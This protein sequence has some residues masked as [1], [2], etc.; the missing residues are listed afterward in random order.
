MQ[1]HHLESKISLA[2]L[3]LFLGSPQCPPWKKNQ[4]PQFQLGTLLVREEEKS[5][6]W[7]F[8]WLCVHSEERCFLIVC[9]SFK[10]LKK[11]K[12]S[13]LCLN[14]LKSTHSQASGNCTAKELDNCV[15]ITLKESKKTVKSSGLKERNELPSC[16]CQSQMETM[17]H[18]G[19]TLVY[20]DMDLS[21]SLIYWEQ[22]T[23]WTPLMQSQS[24][25]SD[26]TELLLI[27]RGKTSLASLFTL[28]RSVNEKSKSVLCS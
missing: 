2:Q 16:L 9:T 17:L 27:R 11:R 21:S 8:C 22:Q 5:T 7:I 4:L 24:S 18:C 20:Y 15:G 10:R 12:I 28:A 14:V 13:G 23:S 6:S 25:L 1:R 3:Q 19:L 26:Q